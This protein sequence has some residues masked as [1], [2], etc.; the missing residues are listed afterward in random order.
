[1]Q[2]FTLP[3]EELL[4][5]LSAQLESGGRATL[6]VTGNSMY[7]TFRNRADAV[8][9]IPVKHSL[10]K[11]DL[12]LYRR[13]NGQ[14]VLHRIVTKPKNGSFFCTGDNQWVLETV[15]NEQVL[16]LV[17]GFIRSGKTCSVQNR[18][19]HTWVA[20]W[21]WLRP[22]RRPILALGKAFGRLRRKWKHKNMSF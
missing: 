7:P 22:V 5:I 9:L 17:D 6:V 16:A 4:P 3:M 14:Y 11:G 2:L 21:V 10:K 1:M 18:Q 8:Y 12:I 13:G 15:T 19:Y 20:V